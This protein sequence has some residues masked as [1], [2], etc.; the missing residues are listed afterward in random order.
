MILDNSLNINRNYTKDRY[1]NEKEATNLLIK[2][3]GWN[4]N[5]KSNIRARSLR[6][7]EIIRNSPK[8]TGDLDTFLQTF[9]LDNPDGISLM[10]L[11]EALLRIPDKQTTDEL[12][13][14]KITKLDWK[15]NKNNSFFGKYAGLGLSLTK[16]TLD[17]SL[18][19]IGKPIIRKSMKQA[20]EYMGGKF[21]LG[22][23][24]EKAIKNSITH[25]K[26][27]YKLSYDMLGEGARTFEDAEKYFESYWQAIEY[28]GTQKN[29]KNN[30][31]SVKLSA[32]HPRYEFLK[33]TESV[34][35]IRTKLMELCK[36]AASFDISL[37][38]DAE[39]SERLDISLDILA[40][41]S[42][43]SALVGWNGLGLAVQSYQKRAYSLLDTLIDMA[44]SHNRKLQIRL[45]KG[46]YWD[47]EIKKSQS[48]SH[49][50][51]PVFTK[52]YHT[53]LS[54]LAC[55][56]KMLYEKDKIY[57]M[58]ATH[59]AHTVS[60]ILEMDRNLSGGL[61]GGYEFQRLFGMGER[62]YD[63]ILKENIAPVSIYAPVG[64]HKE[65]L[66]YL[67][68]RLLEN[69]ANSSFVNKIN[70]P[71]ISAEEL[72][73]CPIEETKINL[74]EKN[75]NIPLPRNIYKSRKNSESID[76]TNDK[77]ISSL[78]EQINKT[79]ICEAYSL[80]N[81]KEQKNGIIKEIK[82]PAN[83]S[84]IIGKSYNATYEDIENSCKIAAS[85]FEKWNNTNSLQRAEILKKYA[86]LLEKNKEKFIYLCVKE[87]GK[88]IK[89]AIDEVR[90]AI[91]FARY[92]AVNGEKIFN[93]KGTL[94][95]SIT[96]EENK[97]YYHGKGVFLC[98]SPWNFPLAIFSGQITAALMA[99]NAVIAKPAEQ[100]PIIAIETVKLLIEAGIPKNVISL[101]IGD[102][103][104]GAKLVENK[105][106][107]GVVFTGSTQTAKSINISLAKK[108]GPISTL[109][110]E[111]GGIN[112]MIVDSSALPEQVVDDVILSAFG[113]AGQRCSALRILCLH[114]DIAPT[115]IEMLIGAIK[116][117]KI[118]N[119]LQ[120]DTDIGPVIDDNALSMLKRHKSRIS[121]FGK[122]IAQ[123]NDKELYNG[124]YFAPTIAEIN[125]IRAIK[126]EIFGPFLHIIKYNSNKKDELI[127]DINNL[128]Y[129]L[130]FGAHSRIDNNLKKLAD[131]INCGNIYLNRSMIGAIV[132]S[133]PFGG[134]AL[135][136]TG[137]K[138]GGQDY[139][140]AFANEK[141]ISKNLTISGGNFQLLN[142]RDQI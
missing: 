105:N 52:K 140:K 136:G 137:P 44:E 99:G 112:A 34:P 70:N 78:L 122:I 108:N 18:S 46:A 73:K 76:L 33:Y 7:I 65:L 127:N 126:E 82:N 106:I 139:L 19:G 28:I 64:T 62:L 114:T 32:L 118:G 80:I 89:D 51:Y 92:Y 3:L 77:E 96:G 86:D 85:A 53:D 11:A 50:D 128:G 94:L 119:P 102:G 36:L 26:K 142:I 15:K 90:E 41:I 113:S 123:A 95:E 16:K 20:M 54:Y 74:G 17:G 133:Q 45:V 138:A 60:S 66:A 30:C 91:D 27:G 10:C 120:I 83:L 5:L 110:A 56:Q 63:I 21:I 68:R 59:N 134:H 109:I 55:A 47:S 129:G 93:E 72:I 81:G 101:I 61:S 35:A 111:T 98:I 57:S 100:T 24:I 107:S 2:E 116:T 4:D 132:G 49:P 58:F 125:D 39:E 88:T 69:G 25:E 97:I 79:K 40:K 29:N 84:E 12:I 135:S 71:N 14:D 9:S 42:S 131:N 8:K 121:G 67:V 38:I 124:H 87:A 6:L 104:I 141:T 43:D 117:L 103:K 13:A 31:I 48:Q 115:I 23:S 75:P 22:E 1:K 130:T 37:T